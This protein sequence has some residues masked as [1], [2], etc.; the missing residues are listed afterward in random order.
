MAGQRLSHPEQGLSRKVT[1]LSDFEFR[2]FEQVKLSSDDFGVMPY[3]STIL[4][5][6]N[7]RL[8]KATEKQVWDALRRIVQLKLLIVF[9]HQDESYVCAPQW[10]KW[11]KLSFPRKTPYP[12]PPADALDQCEPE[13]RY[14]F[15]F[16]PGARKIPKQKPESLQSESG[17][18][19]GELL[20]DSKP[21]GAGI[22][23]NANANANANEFSSSEGSLRETKP[24][25]RSVP[26]VQSPSK[27]KHGE[28]EG[29]GF[30]DW[31]CLP[32]DLVDQFAGR[33]ALQRHT[34]AGDERPNVLAWASG[35]MGS[36]V[37]PTG[38][39]YD[40]WNRQWEITHGTGK[41]VEDGAAGRNER[42]KQRLDRFVENG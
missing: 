41:V 23:A 17:I 11:Q 28:H 15:S 20:E 40:F 39:M 1:A 7:L 21:Q 18:T 13:T 6:N 38:K 19:S 31:M 42:T 10:Q 30:C 9:D 27:W 2:V 36:G 33:L 14:L 3:T 37:N 4:R 34:S 16:H 32:V 26:L 12:C 25:L 35:V 8:R 29:G 5:A 22:P 24:M